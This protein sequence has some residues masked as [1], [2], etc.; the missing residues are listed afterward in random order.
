MPAAHLVLLINLASTWFMVGLIW[1]VQ[2]V[3]YPLFA[4]V[5]ETGFGA[6]HKQH[7]RRTTWVVAPLMLIELATSLSLLWLRPI[8]APAWLPWLGVALL[9]IA[10][11]STWRLQIP[12][13]NELAV[14]YAPHAHSGLCRTNWLRTV[15]WTARGLLT[16]YAVT[17]WSQP[18]VG[19]A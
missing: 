11:G 1:F 15:A 8:G 2:I 13:H 9:A 3:H 18:A 19:P 10:W 16:A 12:R 7:V 14:C 17:R 6:Y 5:P 4:A